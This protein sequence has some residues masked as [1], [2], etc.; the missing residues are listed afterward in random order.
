ML[1]KETAKVRL[2][3]SV[4]NTVV[5]FEELV[6]KHLNGTS[7]A[8]A[9]TNVRLNDGIPA[10]EVYSINIKDW[11]TNGDSNKDGLLGDGDDWNKPVGLTGLNVL[12]GTMMAGEFLVSAAKHASANT[13][14]LQLLDANGNITKSWN[15]AIPAGSIDTDNTKYQYNIYRNHLYGI[16]EKTLDN[17]GDPTTP[18]GEDKE[19]PEDLSKDQDIILNISSDWEVIH[20]LELE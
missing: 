8:D 1:E 5:K 20:K 2:V 4:K 11:F 15:V 14:E 6:T 13:F 10:F 16:G 18:G 19:N 9:E 7:E 3:A 17:P 12:E